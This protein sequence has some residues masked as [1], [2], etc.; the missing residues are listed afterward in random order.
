[1][2]SLVVRGSR[3]FCFTFSTVN[4]DQLHLIMLSDDEDLR[5]MQR[6]SVLQ[7]NLRYRPLN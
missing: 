5:L 2:L 1:M 4:P 6:L 3:E 7:Y